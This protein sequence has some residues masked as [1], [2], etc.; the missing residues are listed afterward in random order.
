MTPLPET[1]LTTTTLAAD[2]TLLTRE[3]TT[4]GGISFTARLL[5]PDDAAALGRYFDGLTDAI[6]GMY[7][8]HPLDSG[9]ALLLCSGIDHARCLRYV[10][11]I[12]GKIEGYFILA[13]GLG[14]G[15]ARRYAGYNH[16]L[17]AAECCTFAPS[18]ADAYLSRGIGS[19][20]MPLVVEAAHRMGRR[21]IVLWGGVR[22]DNPRARHFYR[23]FGFE[24]VGSFFAGGVDNLDMGLNLDASSPRVSAPV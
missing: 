23:K 10:V 18:V 3:L 16:P 1:P 14:G 2:P 13:S 5:R 9:H 22:G 24:Q 4:P 6:R 12:R 7:G 15:D 8:P 21:K 20:L 17:E 19:T 11:E